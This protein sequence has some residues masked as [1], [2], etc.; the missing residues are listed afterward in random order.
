MQNQAVEESVFIA[1]IAMLGFAGLHIPKCVNFT[2]GKMKV[3]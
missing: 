2:R 1:P 3:I